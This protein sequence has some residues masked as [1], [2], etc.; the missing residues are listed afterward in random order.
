MEQPLPYDIGK[1]DQASTS[2]GFWLVHDEVNTCL[3]IPPGYMVAITGGFSAENGASGL[4]WSLLD[5]AS[6]ADVVACASRVQDISVAFP[7]VDYKDWKECITKYLVPAVSST[8][9]AEAA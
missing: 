9:G 2:D 7:E 4:R 6:H 5:H 3:Y 8:H 1:L